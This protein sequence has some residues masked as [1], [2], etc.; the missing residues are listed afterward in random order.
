MNLTID[1]VDNLDKSLV[2]LSGE[3]DVY[4]APQLKQALL[5]ITQK[6]GHLVEVNLADVVYMDSTGLG[7]FI[8]ALKNTKEY[9]SHLKL[10]NPQARVSRLFKITGL[11]E[12]MDLQE[13]VQG[14][15]E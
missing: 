12:I 15:K 9:N 11:N 13:T 7:I 4:T 8:S 6:E 2:H 10:V 1:I 5:P 3:L 14:G